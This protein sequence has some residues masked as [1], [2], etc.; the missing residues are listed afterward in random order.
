MKKTII[1]L[2]RFFTILAVSLSVTSCGA[3]MNMSEQDAWDVGYGA[4]TL[5][6]NMI[7]N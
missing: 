4:G 1:N 6:R 5:L 2:T 7:D 3:L